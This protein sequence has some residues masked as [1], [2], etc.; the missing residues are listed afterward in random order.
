VLPKDP[1][2]HQEKWCTLGE[3][4]GAIQSARSPE[5][6]PTS[7][8]AAGAL[9]PTSVVLQQLHDEV[10]KDHFT[11]GWLM[12][13]LG[14]R[15]FGL[16]MFLLAVVA[17][18]PGVS[19]VAGLLLLIPAFQ[20]VMGYPAPVFPD[21]IAARALPTR[22]L[23]AI[24]RRAVPALEYIEKV[25]H[26]RWPTPHEATKRLVGAVVLILTST[27]V[28][29]PL[30]LSNVPPALLIALISLA[31]LQEDGLLLSL[32]LL[33]AITVLTIELVVIR[34]TVI[35]AKWIVGLW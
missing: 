7:P 31:F 5:L 19:I 14:K 15:S 29:A 20:M 30:P 28:F 17:I 11:L 10:P 27:L 25:I 8:S 2:R 35:A 22:Y 13:R 21:R 26:P 34:E 16:I 4:A 12:D 24:V 18:T 6:K 32:A 1:A 33:V 9:V 23:A 3:A